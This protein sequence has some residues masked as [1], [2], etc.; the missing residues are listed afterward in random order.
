M[1]VNILVSQGG[2]A[3]GDGDA[4]HAD[5]EDEDADVAEVEEGAGDDA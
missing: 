4:E 5:D 3:A 2:D 1:D